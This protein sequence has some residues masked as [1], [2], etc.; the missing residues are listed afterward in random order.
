MIGTGTATQSRPMDGTVPFARR[1]QSF[2]VDP[3][4]DLFYC[5]GCGR[6]GDVIR[7]AELYHEVKFPQA[8]ALLHQWRGFDAYIARNRTFY[9]MQLHRHGEAIAYL[10]ERGVRTPEDR[11]HADRLRARRQLSATLADTVGLSAPLC[12]KPGWSLPLATMHIHTASS[13]RWEATS[14]A[15]VCSL[16]R[17]LTASCQVQGQLVWLGAGPAIRR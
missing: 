5:Y 9:R 11:A 4:K 13:F 14:M 8:L 7:F 10:H 2:L 12:V 1:S 16:R 3:N 15:A 6:G 17:R